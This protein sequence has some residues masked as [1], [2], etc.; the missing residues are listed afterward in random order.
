LLG[1]TV[2]GSGRCC[3]EETLVA[4]CDG[5]YHA[6]LSS[7]LSVFPEQEVV[8]LSARFLS[9][10]CHAFGVKSVCQRR[11]D[12]ESSREPNCQTIKGLTNHEV[13]QMVRSQDENGQVPLSAA[14]VFHLL[15]KKV[16]SDR[17][18]MLSLAFTVQLAAHVAT[19]W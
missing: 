10:V 2:S 7:R 8:C 5:F 18:A 9:L 16:A 13:G 12:F 15:L 3:A 14:L 4:C 6:I 11:K 19:R 17:E 1:R